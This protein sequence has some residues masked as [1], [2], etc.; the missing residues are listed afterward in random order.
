MASIK[1]S[2]Q[3]D[4]PAKKKARRSSRGDTA[5]PSH[6]G[7][8]TCTWAS[9]ALVQAY[10]VV[11]AQPQR[12]PT[13]SAGKD[14][15]GVSIPLT[16]AGESFLHMSESRFDSVKRRFGG[17]SSFVSLVTD[18]SG[19][20]SR[21]A[22][23][24]TQLGF[25]PTAK[26]VATR[27]A[28]HAALHCRCVFVLLYESGTSEA[29][30]T[31]STYI[32]N[33]TSSR[34]SSTTASGR[35]RETSNT[36][37]RLQRPADTAHL[38]TLSPNDLFSALSIDTFRLSDSLHVDGAGSG[39][40][41]GNDTTE[42]S[43]Q[44]TAVGALPR[45]FEVMDGPIVLHRPAAR[46]GEH[47]QGLEIFRLAPET[48]SRGE[49]TPRPWRGE[50]VSVPP[51][52]SCSPGGIERA[53]AAAGSGRG[54]GVVGSGAVKNIS[55]SNFRLDLGGVSA[56]DDEPLSSGDSSDSKKG[57]GR[58]G[59]TL[60]VCPPSECYSVH[61]EVIISPSLGRGCEDATAV[62]EGTAA[63]VAVPAVAT[64]AATAAAA[65]TVS[66]S[67][68][69]GYAS[70]WTSLAFDPQGRALLSP[71]HS[72]PP[73]EWG[74]SFTCLCPAPATDSGIVGLADATP[75]LDAGG[76]LV[77]RP[78]PP[79][80][81]VGV[82]GDRRGQES[83]FASG[84]REGD[85]G[86]LLELRGGGILSCARSLP[87]PPSAI[88]SAAVDDGKGV[89][90]VLLADSAGTALLLARDGA[91]FP[92]VE[93]Y[94]GVAAAFAG[95]FLGNGREQVALLPQVSSTPM[96]AAAMATLS[97]A[98]AAGWQQLPLKA[99]VKRALVSDC[100]CV[101]GNGERDDL[102]ALP[103]AGPIYVVDTRPSRIDA[104][105]VEAVGG[106]E[107][108]TTSRKRQRAEGRDAAS[109]QGTKISGAGRAAGSGSK[110][111]EA[112]INDDHRLGRLSTVVGVLRRRVQ[113]EET[114][115]LRLRQARR[116]KAALLSA[117]K[118]A[119]ITQVGG[120][121]G[122]CS[123]AEVPDLLR[124]AVETFSDGLVACFPEATSTA[125]P[126]S[127]E[128]TAVHDTL[129]QPLLCTVNRVR[130]HA[131]SRTLC[132][133]ACVDNPHNGHVTG[134]TLGA[135][136]GLGA[137]HGAAANVCLSL[138]STA[139]RLN[140]RSAV[141]PW[142]AP[143][144][145]AVIRACV[146]V[147]TDLFSGVGALATGTDSLDGTISL[148]AS[149]LWSWDCS[150]PAAAHNV[151]GSSSAAVGEA[152][153]E[154]VGRES[155]SVVFARVLVSS[156]DM[157]GVGVLGSVSGDAALAQATTVTSIGSPSSRYVPPETRRKSAKS[158]P[159]A[160]RSG[161]GSD[162][163]DDDAVLSG[164]RHHPYRHHY[165]HLGLFDVGTRLDLLV[166]SDTSSLSALPQAIS[167][168]SCLA[169]LPEPW[170]GGA[171]ALVEGCSERAAECTLRS[172]DA[173]GASAVLLQVAA[174]VLP[175][176]VKASANHGSEEGQALVAAASQALGE[177]IKAVE[178]VARE[179][180]RAGEETADGGRDGHGHRE[181]RLS[182]ALERYTNAQ[183]RTDVLASQLAGRLLAAAGGGGGGGSR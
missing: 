32:G 75:G 183:M 17:R 152:A 102:A 3:E 30:N 62:A 170:A 91:N 118:L 42:R 37:S 93:E 78:I 79:T 115:L 51:V 125:T 133:D 92:V 25:A 77:L 21:A 182:R 139:G 16:R 61:E 106:S 15:K 132:L 138:A 14:K 130:F 56:G 81:Y 137:G 13:N 169:A 159:R 68:H 26:V 123:V 149:C 129:R 82:A 67:V 142:L 39:R 150:S 2:K 97:K 63:I 90:A 36:T 38:V 72:P 57:N 9:G 47:W 1:K 74:N 64:S 46:L 141:C 114:R 55:E 126:P 41:G 177:E 45:A 66:Q 105:N 107:S 31:D 86:A 34:S 52:V 22:G 7:P 146:E 128:S 54:N 76:G 161:A 158:L 164:N 121:C 29:S 18:R 80:V 124:S 136:G 145:S 95:D 109:E 89:L 111:Q 166:R 181:S 173:V 73:S 58:G 147:P 20:G 120:S 140:T 83:A 148:Y 4:G 163:P 85:R 5:S 43:L 153:R 157:L 6:Y 19:C 100:S 108:T 165:H 48:G 119:L 172:G 70:S 179:R 28:M 160:S 40:N 176:G 33:S 155:S 101:W 35:D 143:G 98:G 87:A 117:A 175:D 99:L 167:A 127:G 110:R 104:G 49:R 71:R 59:C 151:E 24:G 135:G 88:V 94:R 103:G 23:R 154:H 116:G 168:L 113:A 60:L 144:N 44:Q 162:D 122:S 53:A 174:G 69:S 96:S 8:V 11:E 156:L 27:E 171:A 134:D 178:A 84:G 12:S 10:L 112:G 131:P 180:H 65:A 50:R